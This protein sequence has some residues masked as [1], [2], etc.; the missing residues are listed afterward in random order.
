MIPIKK[1]P[2]ISIGI[3]SEKKIYFDLYGEFKVEGLNQILS[4]RFSAELIKD[5]ILCKKGDEIFE[6]QMKFYLNP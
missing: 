1:E 4:G 3:L 6:F 5:K 2:K